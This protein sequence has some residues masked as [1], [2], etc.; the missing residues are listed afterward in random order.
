[1]EGVGVAAPTPVAQADSSQGATPSVAAVVS[2]WRRPRA[3]DVEVAAAGVF[4]VIPWV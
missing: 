2:S 3:G 4:M 1:M